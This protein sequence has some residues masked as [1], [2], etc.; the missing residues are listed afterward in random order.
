M[1]CEGMWILSYTRRTS[2]Q[3]GLTK[4][5]NAHTC[6][7]AGGIEPQW[8]AQSEGIKQAT[9]VIHLADEEGMKESTGNRNM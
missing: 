5:L 6:T 9:T 3:G 7:G 2:I 1:A 4:E 8:K